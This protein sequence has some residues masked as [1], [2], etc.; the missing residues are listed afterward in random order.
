MT[1]H[2]TVLFS[3]FPQNIYCNT[4]SS[5]ISAKCFSEL[6]FVPEI[7]RS[8]PT[9][10]LQIRA[11]LKSTLFGRRQNQNV[12]LTT[13]HRQDRSQ[14]NLTFLKLN[15]LWQ[16]SETKLLL[17]PKNNRQNSSISQKCLIRMTSKS[18]SAFNEFT[19]TDPSHSVHI[20]DLL[21]V[22]VD[23]SAAAVA[24]RQNRRMASRRCY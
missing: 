24:A 17:Q 10:A 7:N 16:W 18:K 15:W 13:P 23:Q 12:P 5:V 21:A 1:Y 8:M 9:V 14:P 22:V 2:I 11:Y 6:G 20:S 19:R 4:I 3:L